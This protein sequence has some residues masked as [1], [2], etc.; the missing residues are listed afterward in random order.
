MD[1]ATTLPMVPAVSHCKECGSYYGGNAG[2][3]Y[4]SQLF[5]EELGLPLVASSYAAVRAPCPQAAALT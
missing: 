1:F 2:H 3:N 5:F 4:L